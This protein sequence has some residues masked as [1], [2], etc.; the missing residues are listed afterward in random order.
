M[1]TGSAFRFFSWLNLPCS[2]GSAHHLPMNLSAVESVSRLMA[3]TGMWL[4][5]FSAEQTEAVCL[6]LRLPFFFW[7]RG[8]GWGREGIPSGALAS[9]PS[10]PA[11]PTLLT[12]ILKVA[13][14]G[15][16][17]C[18]FQPVFPQHCFQKVPGVWFCCVCTREMWNWSITLLTG[19]LWLFHLLLPVDVR[20]T[21]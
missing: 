2:S 11:L 8:R 16:L 5:H 20:L 19:K 3:S 9:V 1:W 14:S 13:G 10:H 17:G 4:L 6:C 21:C 15:C 12:S 18:G 7:L